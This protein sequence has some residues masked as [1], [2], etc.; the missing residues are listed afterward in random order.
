MELSTKYRIIRWDMRGHANSD[1]PEQD[2]FYSKQHQIDDM[3]AV[4]DACGVKAA[5]FVGHSMG[6]YD[7]LLF[8][9]AGSEYAAYVKALVLFAT[10][11]GFQK[12]EARAAWNK[13]AEKMANAFETKGLEALVGSDKSKGHRNWRGWPGKPCLL[14]SFRARSG[15]KCTSGE[16]PAAG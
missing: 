7:N 13:Q 6:A 8:A 3:R 5:V 2:L 12:D 16:R 11:P 4:L 9:F 1:S 14:S 15:Q 10:G